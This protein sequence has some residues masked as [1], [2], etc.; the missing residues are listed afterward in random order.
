MPTAA[1]AH[2]KEITRVAVVL[3]PI[4]GYPRFHRTLSSLLM[5]HHRT[6]GPPSPG[7]IVS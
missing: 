7:C 4:H 6:H 1:P 2:E 5:A 3:D